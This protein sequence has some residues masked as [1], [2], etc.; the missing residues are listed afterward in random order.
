MPRDD[1]LGMFV[2]DCVER[3]GGFGCPFDVP[4]SHGA[5]SLHREPDP[6]SVGFSTCM[7]YEIRDLQ[8][9]L[10]LLGYE[11]ALR[12]LFHAVDEA[13][14]GSRR[15]GHLSPSSLPMLLSISEMCC[16]S[17]SI[18]SVRVSSRAAISST[19]FARVS[20]RAATPSTRFVRVANN[21]GSSRSSSVRISRRTAS[22]ASGCSR[23]IL[24][25]SSIVVGAAM[26]LTCHPHPPLYQL[27][28]RPRLATPAEG[29]QG[30]TASPGCRFGRCPGGS[31]R[32][33]RWCSRRAWGWPGTV[34]ACRRG[35]ATG[36]RS[37]SPRR[38]PRS[39]G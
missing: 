20:S 9:R 39:G 23:M 32:C 34:G 21:S 14:F 28:L 11:A 18:R 19:R 31:G 30:V 8:P 37:S 33:R 36:R 38:W 3:G 13:R 29:G 35:A 1:R 24:M 10:L 17:L 12:G 6:R 27:D 15:H 26:D 22:R 2:E 7:E 4:W 5:G 16:V 25:M